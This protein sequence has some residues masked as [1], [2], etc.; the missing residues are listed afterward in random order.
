MLHTQKP[1]KSHRVGEHSSILWEIGQVAFFTVNVNGRVEETEDLNTHEYDRLRYSTS[2]KTM[3]TVATISSPLHRSAEGLYSHLRTASGE[4]L[5]EYGRP[6]NNFRLQHSALRADDVVKPNC[7]LNV[8]IASFLR[9]GRINFAFQLLLHHAATEANRVP[10]LGCESRAEGRVFSGSWANEEKLK[11][12]I[13]RSATEHLFNVNSYAIWL[14][15][16]TVAGSGLG[17]PVE[18]RHRVSASGRSA[19]SDAD[20]GA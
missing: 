20:R 7:S 10:P 18:E 9:I 4:N 2:E 15:D 11:T 14:R 17:E 3:S 19:T 5:R 13:R 1:T 8:L 16:L 12:A 6:G